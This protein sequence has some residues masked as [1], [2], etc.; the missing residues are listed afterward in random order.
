MESISTFQDIGD[1]DM[2]LHGLVIALVVV[3]GTYC[4]NNI[5]SIYILLKSEKEYGRRWSDIQ[6]E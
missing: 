5:V 2:L 3:L 6:I 1:S 4:L